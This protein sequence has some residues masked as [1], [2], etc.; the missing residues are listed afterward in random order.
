L[1]VAPVPLPLY[2]LETSWSTAAADGEIC[3]GV[4]DGI[5]LT[6]MLSEV[7]LRLADDAG[8]GAGVD[9]G[10]TLTMMPSEVSL[11]LRLVLLLDLH[12]RQESMV[13]MR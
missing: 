2:C 3:A 13:F 8:G 9:D 12:P 5:T 10:I 11:P 6:M 4:V 1:A 7:F